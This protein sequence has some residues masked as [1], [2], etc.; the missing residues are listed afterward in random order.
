MAADSIR[1]ISRHVKK[2]HCISQVVQDWKFV[3]QVLDRI[4]LWLFLIV[5]VMGSVLIFTPSLKMWLHSYHE[6][7]VSRAI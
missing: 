1:Y 7:Q 5:S 3:A 6:E 2:E 4:F